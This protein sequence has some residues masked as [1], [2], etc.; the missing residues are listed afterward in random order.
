MYKIQYSLSILPSFGEHKSREIQKG[1][2]V[3]KW[4]NSG[5]SLMSVFY[6]S[7]EVNIFGTRPVKDFIE[8]KWNNLGYKHHLFGSITHVIHIIYLCFY[9]NSVYINAIWLE[10]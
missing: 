2:V 4:Y 1:K 7:K 10:Y 3:M 8:V 9:I 5:I 6:Y